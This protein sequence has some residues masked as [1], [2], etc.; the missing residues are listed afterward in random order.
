VERGELDCVAAPADLVGADGGG[1]RLHERRGCGVG[2]EHEVVVPETDELGD[3]GVAIVGVVGEVEG[4]RVVVELEVGERGDERFA[5][6][7]KRPHRVFDL[8]AGEEP[9][10]ARAMRDA[11][12]S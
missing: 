1:D 7:G 4:R 8:G 5:A 12:A 2:V 11:G 10:A 9:A 3:V 6:A